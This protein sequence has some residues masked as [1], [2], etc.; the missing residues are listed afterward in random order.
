MTTD[1]TIPGNT[2]YEDVSID[3]SA[4]PVFSGAEPGP[5][6]R[7]STWQS[8]VPTSRGPKPYPRWLVTSAAAFDT[9]LGIVKS[10]KEADLFL[11]ERAVPGDATLTCLLAAKRYRGAE[12]SD[13]QRSA[14]YQEGRKE[15]D[16][17]SARAMAR[18]SAYGRTVAAGRWAYAEFEFLR[19]LFERGL[20]VPYP[21]QVNETEVL[22]EFIGVDG[23]AATR[24]AQLKLHG[25]ELASHYEQ[26]RDILIGFAEAGLAHGDLSPYNLL[27]HDGR[28]VVIDL[29]QVVDLAANPAGL[30]FLYRDCVNVCTWFVRRGFACDAEV[31]FGEL[32]ARSY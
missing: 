10:G 1:R 8:V 5:G 11:I 32:V 12:T 24:L 13:F 15:R 16:S 19:L 3:A 9:E 18:G 26:V 20:P 27:V 21:V 25:R 29:P 30:E 23:V 31:L 7:W 4:V 14:R 2:F 22:M 17:R 6:Q 28:V